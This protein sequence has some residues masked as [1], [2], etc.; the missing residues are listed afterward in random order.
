MFMEFTEPSRRLMHY[1]EKLVTDNKADSCHSNTVSFNNCMI[2]I[3]G[4]YNPKY[5]GFN[6]EGK[7][8]NIPPKSE[9]R[10]I[11]KWDGYRLNIRWLLKGY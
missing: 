7:V 11:Q 8:V 4:S 6:E 9:V 3:P 2:R 5:I 1:A 10:I